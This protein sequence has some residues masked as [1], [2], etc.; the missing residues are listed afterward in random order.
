MILSASMTLTRHNGFGNVSI[1]EFFLF[2]SKALRFGD[3]KL[4][5]HNREKVPAHPVIASNCYNL[6]DQT[7]QIVL[8][9]SDASRPNHDF[10]NR[11]AA[12]AR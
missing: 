9:S 2:N 12:H 4:G 10:H 3:L 5:V 8:V 6:L 1:W 7:C 11:N